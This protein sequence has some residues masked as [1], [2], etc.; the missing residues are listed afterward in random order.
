MWLQHL[1]FK[2]LPVP[3]FARD[4]T[5]ACARCARFQ[6]AG[7]GVD[8]ARRI[9]HTPDK[10]GK[11]FAR[12]VAFGRRPIRSRIAQARLGGKRQQKKF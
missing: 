1:V 8:A 9:A 7:C 3:V 12:E 4:P 11:Y 10:L 6:H 5:V 2:F